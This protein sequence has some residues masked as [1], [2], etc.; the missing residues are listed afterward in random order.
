MGGEAVGPIKAQCPSVRQG[1][2]VSG[3][4]GEHPHR[5]RGRE[6]KIGK[7]ITFEM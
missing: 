1:V 7:G 2:G 5:R 6:D 4:V 3:W